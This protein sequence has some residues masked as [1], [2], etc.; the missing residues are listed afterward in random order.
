M[1]FEIPAELLSLSKTTFSPFR[2]DDE[3]G[4]IA[5]L[6]VGRQSTLSKERPTQN[7]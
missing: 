2:K 3:L 1:P 4:K 5:K 6:I 7:T